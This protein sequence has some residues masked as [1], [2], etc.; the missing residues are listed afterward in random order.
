MPN[1]RTAALLVGLAAAPFAA[2]DA[3]SRE[4]TEDARRQLTRAR[5]GGNRLIR[6]VAEQLLA[7]GRCGEP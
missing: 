4:L 7:S 6:I 2:A 5:D 1:L 3:R